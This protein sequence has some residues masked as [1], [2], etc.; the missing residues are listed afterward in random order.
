M[1]TLAGRNSVFEALRA[2]RRT[3]EQISIAQGAAQRGVLAEI[4]ALAAKRSI[5]VRQV[6]RQE[7]D[8]RAGEIKHQGVIAQVA[9]YPY[10]STDDMLALAALRS[11]QP[12]LLAL[13]LVQD[14]QNLG[15]LVRACEAV[16]VHGILLPGRRSVQVTPAVSRASDGAVEHLLIASVGNLTNALNALKKQ[17]VWVVGIEEH[18]RSQ[19]YRQVDLNMPLALV[20]GSEGRGMRRL[21]ADTCDLLISLPM[22]G[23]INSLNVA[24]AGA[25]VLYHALAAR[26][27][28]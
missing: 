13:D 1:E 15:T 27:E 11:E 14:P 18:P 10:A 25:V 12:F 4:V 2:G 9:S 17:G 24:S 20:L 19:D 8:R 22:R 16:G 6:R 28:R 7:L 21:V 3:I 26:T 23:E 5:P